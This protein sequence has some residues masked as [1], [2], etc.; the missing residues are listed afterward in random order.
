MN[1][2]NKKIRRSSILYLGWLILLWTSWG[3]KE[4]STTQDWVARV[5]ENYLYEE[6]L[7][8]IIP[9]GVSAQDSLNMAERY[10]DKWISRKLLLENAQENTEYNIQE[11][12]KKVED[13]RSALI[14]YEFEK[15]YLDDK[16]KTEITSAEVEKFYEENLSEFE[17]KQPI[18]KGRFVKITKKA[19]LPSGFKDW[20]RSE[21]EG[22]LQK[23]K[24]Y[25]Y[26][27]ADAFNLEDSLWLAFDE[28][29][30]QTPLES[31]PNKVNFL[32]F[33]QFVETADTSHHY[34]LYIKDYKI[35]DQIS[36]IEFVEDRIKSMIINQRKTQLIKEL[37]TDLYQKAEKENKIE[38]YKAKE[39]E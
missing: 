28:L 31:I 27:N 37:E 6:E 12:N 38:L 30:Q 15:K 20:L 32:K 11:I 3:C 7:A 17:L 1:I 9:S 8:D 18:V 5:G 10:I 29:I 26:T 2:P 22:D 24:E 21:K 35:A 23:L 16:L 19:K 39:D 14:T 34:Y 36:P 13:Y 33:N 4:Q 25:C